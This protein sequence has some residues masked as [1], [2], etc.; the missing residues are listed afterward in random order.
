[1]EN[2]NWDTENRLFLP[3][4]RRFLFTATAG[5]LLASSGLAE[6][7]DAEPLPPVEPPPVAPA[8]EPAFDVANLKRSFVAGREYFVLRS[9]R[10]QL[11]AQTDRA[12]VAPAFLLLAFDARNSK[13]SGRKENAFNFGDGA[14]F[15]RSALQVFLGDFPFTALGHETQTRWVWIDGIPAVEAQWWAGGLLVIEH[16]FALHDS[17]TFIRRISLSSRNLAGTEEIRLRLS[18]PQGATATRDGWLIQENDGARLALAFDNSVPGQLRPQQ[19]DMEIGP[20]AVPP[21]KT[22]T[23]DTWLRV[24]VLPDDDPLPQLPSVTDALPQTTAVWRSVSSIV[25]EDDT[26]RDLFDKARCG[27]AAMVADTGVMDAGI[28]EYGGQWVRDT[29]NTLVGL[30]H[31]GHFELVRTAFVQLL[32]NMISADGRTM[33][34]GNFDDPDREEFDQMGE[35]MHALRSYV[36]WTGDE[37]LVR[38]YRTRLV[39]LVERPLRSEFRHESGLLHNRREF[40]ERTLD[41]GFELVYQ[42]YV[43]LGLRFAASLAIP[44]EATDSAARWQNEADRILNVTF[45]HPTLA[46][47]D[48][49]RLL[50]RRSISGAPVRYVHT[51]PSAADVPMATEGVHLAEPDSAVAL[52]IALGVVDPHSALARNS[53]DELE[54][55]WNARWFCGGYERYHSSG[56]GDQPGPWPCATCFILRA[57]HDA[58]LY[59][60][61]RRTLEWLNTVQGGRTGAWFEE[62]PIVR[63]QAPTAGI[64]PWNSG[65]VSLFLVRH[66]LGVRFDGGQLVLRPALFPASPRIQ[67]DLR[68]RSSR[69]N[70]DIPG[71]GPF[72][73]AQVNG[74]RVR[75]DH[76]GA[77]RVP[78]D[79]EGGTI[80]FHA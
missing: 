12:D 5:T 72:R 68:F 36:D 31:A 2:P 59:D 21:G 15:V 52:P 74:H 48:Q 6:M 8:D 45:S 61:S 49:G 79:F 76:S 50:K 18:L 69:I 39:A 58:G 24:T 62:I 26:V 60:C 35:L 78:A 11:F 32:G 43:A 56:Q 20:L 3:S 41:D 63:S 66:L 33:M 64:L 14:G 13:Q 30:L 57:Q 73:F 16:L 28:F 1:M 23:V 75:A 67:A 25:T 44:L 40:W 65:E 42:I 17:G 34:S 71:P 77:I 7:A 29:S 19:A 70:L 27:L 22:V 10:I 54:R 51:D 37:S 4:R 46:L 9:G 53:L 47:V 80:S 55:L 38:E